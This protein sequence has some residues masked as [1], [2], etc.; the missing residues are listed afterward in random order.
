MKRFIEMYQLAVIVL[1][2]MGDITWSWWWVLAPAWIGVSLVVL[3][4]FI[5]WM[6]RKLSPEYDLACSFK[7]YGEALTKRS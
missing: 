2:L 3:G 7:E 1:K 4:L 6:A 5:K